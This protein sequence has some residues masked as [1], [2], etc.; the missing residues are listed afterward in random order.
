MV[1]PKFVTPKPFQINLPPTNGNLPLNK[2]QLRRKKRAFSLINY[3]SPQK[4]NLLI[5]RLNSEFYSFFK[6]L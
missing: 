2:T 1:P 5:Y 3:T 6:C 4:L